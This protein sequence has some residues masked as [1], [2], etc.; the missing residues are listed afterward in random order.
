MWQE[1]QRGLGSGTFFFSPVPRPADIP[2]WEENDTAGCPN[3]QNRIV[4]RPLWGRK[5]GFLERCQR[6]Q[7]RVTDQT[8]CFLL[9]YDTTTTRHRP[10]TSIWTCQVST[11]TGVTYLLGL[12]W[13]GVTVWNF[14]T[15]LEPP[16]AQLE[17]QAAAGRARVSKMS[18]WHGGAIMVKYADD[19]RDHT[20][21]CA[22]SIDRTHTLDCSQR[23]YSL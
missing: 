20:A 19:S 1:G 10:D 18:A 22:V 23:H 12:A 13:T 5:G 11:V 15:R 9:R 7:F 4:K 6:N 3:S 14:R 2:R 8:H 16:G 21:S 17:L